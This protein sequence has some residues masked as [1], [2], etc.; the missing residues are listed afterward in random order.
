MKLSII[1]PAFNEA[2][3]LPL[4]HDRI[5]AVMARRQEEW[6]WIIVDDHSS[7]G[8]FGVVEEL[9]LRDPRIRGVRL[10]RNSGSH[11]AI[12]C[13]LH[14]AA[15]DAAALLVSDLQDPPELIAQMLDR[16][17][18]GAQVV[19]AV[20]RQRPGQ[21]QHKAFATVYYWMM[22]RLVGLA[23]MPARGADFF[24]ID[25][26]VVDA[27]CRS[28]DRN[29]SV[30]ALITWLGFRQDSIEYDK[31]PRAH[32]RT[33]WTVARKVKLVVDS[34]V[35]F[36]DFP[37][38]W[39]GYIGL[40]LMTLAGLVGV[41]ALFLLPT[42]GAGLLLVTALVLG[43]S[44]L[45]LLALSVVGQYAWRAVDEARRRPAYSIEAVAGTRQPSRL[46]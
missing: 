19:W 46:G 12:A 4:L 39:C 34:V 33:G 35:P 15:G 25:R 2:V 10:A 7:D 29:V 20:R 28:A 36:S 8:T 9:V 40:G 23:G 1:T 13:G 44:G 32:G 43:L 37:I 26:L 16:W 41:S 5:A 27:F 22:R 24:L 31:Q 21:P 14:L 45:Q 17:Q 6:E 38:R 3:N 42:L 30:F 11:V 18:N